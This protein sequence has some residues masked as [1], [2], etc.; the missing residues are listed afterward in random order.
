MSI[1]SKLML[2]GAAGAG[3]GGPQYFITEITAG[4]TNTDARNMALIALDSA[5]NIYVSFDY[6]ESGSDKLGLIS[7]DTS[8]NVLTQKSISGTKL[9]YNDFGYGPYDSIVDSNGDLRVIAHN[10]SGK[11]AVLKIATSDLSLTSSFTGT[12]NPYEPRGGFFDSSGNVYMPGIWSGGFV[13]FLGKYN[14]SG[15]QQFFR[16]YQ[17]NDFASNAA[18]L[19]PMGGTVDSSGNVFMCGTYPYFGYYA[20]FAKL[21][22]SGVFQSSRSLYSSGR[23]NYYNDAYIDSSGNIYVAGTYAETSGGTQIAFVAKYNS[24]LTLQWRRQPTFVSDPR[25]S[26][27]QSVTVDSSGNVY[28]AGRVSEDGTGG[29]FSPSYR[30]F[31][32]YAKYNSSGTLQWQR[33]LGPAAANNASQPNG[34]NARILLDSNEDMIISVSMQTGSNA[35]T[36]YMARLPN[37]GSLTGTYTEAL[38]GETAFSD[39]NQNPSAL[40]PTLNNSSTATVSTSSFGG[41]GASATFTV[42]T[43]TV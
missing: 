9:R 15:T 13:G 11:L 14:A 31:G 37:D 30:W 4:A 16:T 33:G 10:S 21:N 6:V 43:E 41:S 12:P 3:G 25:T 2:L 42:S 36:V 40:T 5:D 17:F 19:L 24:S 23:N 27:L 32:F 38:Y 18:F 7:F 39:F 28:V 29:D 35:S 34:A 26:A 22:S 8:G 20:F 1:S